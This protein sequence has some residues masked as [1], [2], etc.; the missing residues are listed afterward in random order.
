MTILEQVQQT[1]QFIQSK[2]QLTPQ[3]G[4]ILGTGLGALAQELTIETTLS[5]ESI[6]HF[7]L[8]TVEF[9]SGKLLLGTLGDKP[10]VVMQ[11]RFHFYE[12]Y[13]MQ[14]ITFPVRVMHALGVRTLLVSNAAGGLNPAFQTTDLMV[15]DD[16]IS[17]LLPQ[18]PLVGPNPPEFG[19]RF[20]DMSEPYSKSLIDQSL[21]IADELGIRL[22]RGVYVSVTGPQL[23]TRAEYRMLRQWGADAVGMSTVPEVIVANQMGMAVF[24]VSVITDMCIPE[25][26]EKADIQKIIAAAGAAEPHLTRLMRTLVSQL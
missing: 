23:E 15:I 24:G 1:T 17:L 21:A 22:Q 14:Q 2:T 19:D 26:L 3:I 7:P 8:S 13:S 4:I 12:G 25:T 5:Y 9:H 16:H 6:P 18:N 20:P 11:G 10:V